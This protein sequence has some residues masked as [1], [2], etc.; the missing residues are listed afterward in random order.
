MLHRRS[1]LRV[2]SFVLIGA[3]TLPIA[4][5]SDEQIGHAQAVF[6]KNGMVVSVGSDGFRPSASIFCGAAAMPWMR[7]SPWVS[8][9]PVTLAARRQSRR[10]RFHARASSPTLK[11]HR[12]RLSR[13]CSCIDD[14]T[15][16]FLDANGNFDPEKSRDCGARRRCARHG[17][18]AS[19]S[20][21]GD[22]VGP[23]PAR[24]SRRAGATIGARGHAGRLTKSPI[25]LP[26]TAG[27]PAG[28][29]R[30]NISQTGRYG[31]ALGGPLVQRDLA[32]TLEDDR[33]ARP[34]RFLRRPDR[35]QDRRR[36]AGRRR[37]HDRR[38]Y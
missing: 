8:R 5:R 23:F 37:R 29:P 15:K 32:N 20:R 36:S 13:D 19:L 21:R 33:Q 12:D 17:R 31:L 7:P 14:E 2:A 1:I 6:A 35:R 30:Q 25:C 26:R 9:L 16:L 22:T 3:L 18:R 24:R 28:R 27:S 34:P 4:A 11:K 10:R 38:R